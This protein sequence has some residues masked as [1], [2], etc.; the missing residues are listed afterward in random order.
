MLTTL[1]SLSRVRQCRCLAPLHACSG[2]WTICFSRSLCRRPQSSRLCPSSD[3]LSGPQVTKGVAG[4]EWL[5]LRSGPH[6]PNKNVFSDCLKTAVWQVRLSEVRRQIA[7]DSRSSCTEGSVAQVV[8]VR[9]TV[10]DRRCCTNM[11]LTL[12]RRDLIHPASPMHRAT[13]WRHECLS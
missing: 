6:W 8:R 2:L 13:R 10:A 9:L 11:A 3:V 12:T 7:P 1:L 4:M 5:T